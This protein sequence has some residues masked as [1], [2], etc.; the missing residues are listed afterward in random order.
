VLVGCGLAHDLDE[1]AI[2]LAQVHQIEQEPEVAGASALEEPPHRW[3]RFALS[4]DRSEDRPGISD[5]G[6]RAHRP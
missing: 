3:R 4:S 5:G 1:A 2:S 6:V